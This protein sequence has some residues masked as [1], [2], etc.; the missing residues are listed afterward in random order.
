MRY[1]ETYRLESPETYRLES[2]ETYADPS[3]SRGKTE[4]G[5]KLKIFVEIFPHETN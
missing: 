1:T 2:P 4:I 5:A 3:L